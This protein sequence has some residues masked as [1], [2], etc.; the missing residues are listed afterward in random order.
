MTTCVCSTCYIYDMTTRYK[1]VTTTCYDY[2]FFPPCTFKTSLNKR[3]LTRRPK[4]A[5]KCHYISQRSMACD[6]EVYK[7]RLAEKIGMASHAGREGHQSIVG[8]AK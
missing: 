8:V 3:V 4:V 1:Y 6:S 2:M 5:C 7:T